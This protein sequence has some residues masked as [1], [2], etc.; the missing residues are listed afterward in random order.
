MKT[1][2][3]IALVTV[4]LA[5]AVTRGDIAVVVEHQW[6]IDNNYLS[7]FA[8]DP[9]HEEFRSGGYNAGQS[10]RWSHILSDGNEPWTMEGDVILNWFQLAL[11]AR[12]GN[13]SNSGSYNL[14]GMNYNPLDGKYF[15]TGIGIL[16]PPS[17]SYRLAS[18]CDLAVLDNRLP[19]SLLTL[20][21]GTTLS[22]VGGIY[23]L[24][25]VSQDPNGALRARFLSRGVQPGDRIILFAVD[26]WAQV[27]PGTYTVTYVV[28]ET[29]IW[30]DRDPCWGPDTVT[31]GVGYIMSLT[32]HLTLATFRERIPLFAQQPNN[33]PKANYTGG[34]SPDG[35]TL[36]LAEQVSGNMIAVN[37]QVKEDFSIFIPKERFVSYVQAQVAAGRHKAWI[38]PLPAYTDAM[39]TGWTTQPTL[40]LVD[41]NC[42]DP[43]W[44]GSKSMA[45]TFQAAGA[46]LALNFGD[47]NQTLLASYFAN[48]RFAIHGGTTGGQ[49]ISFYAYEPGGTP[50]TPMI[51]NPPLAGQ[52]TLVEIPASQ[53]GVTAI[54]GVVWRNLYPGSR[55]TF[56]LD[57]IVLAYTDPPPPHVGAFDP[58][59]AG[60]AAAQVACDS[61]GRV[62]F[63]EGE[64]DDIIWT[65]DGVNFTTFLTSAE[66][67]AA[68]DSVDPETTTNNLQVMGLTIDRMG[69]VYWSDNQTKG[70]WKAPVCGGAENVRCLATKD[71]IRTA[72]NLPTSPRGLNCF[73]IRGTELLTFNFVD[74]NFIFKVDLET[75][76]YGDFDG[77]V[78]V[79]AADLQRMGFVL[80]GPDIT[81]PPP[82]W[83]ELF[84][85]SDLDRDGDA[86]LGDVRKLQLYG[87]GALPPP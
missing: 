65:A 51:L 85:W 31:T 7:A 83:E 40:T 16:R 45:V 10:I 86:D 38:A 84:A 55:P 50:G 29:E 75:W 71:E 34:L 39:A 5:G 63:S 82:E 22:N 56:Y 62:W 3:A 69:T 44:K 76:D 15:A 17:G 49:P 33:G 66:V 43:V 78:D 24:T 80:L 60:P 61:Q 52:W 64:T 48:V 68:P 77:D 46:Q 87:T 28:S 59:G 13:P 73:T 2:L 70:I 74:G 27:L 4:L 25:D 20:P 54:G 37:T 11:F 12:D 1:H 72:L 30:L 23:S 58:N 42:T 6:T 47:P 36:Y 81:T 9:Q 19:D 21:T 32:P 35:L 41:P 18:E 53:L 79:D 57:H 26:T 14:W 8:Y 67:A